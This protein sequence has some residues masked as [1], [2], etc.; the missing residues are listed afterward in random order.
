MAR[1]IV[2]VLSLLVL[3]A[4]TLHAGL[5][6]LATSRLQAEAEAGFAAEGKAGAVIAH[7]E[8]VRGGYPFAARVTFPELRY[9]GVVQ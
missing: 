6:F 1:R 7:G 4:A 8:P 9:R 5:W 2:T 3:G